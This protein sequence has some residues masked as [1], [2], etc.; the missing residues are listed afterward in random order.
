MSHQPAED[1]SRQACG[2]LILI[3]GLPGS[4]KTTLALSLAGEPA[5][6]RM[7]A[8]AWMTALDINLWEADVRSRVEALQW[9]VAKDLLVAGMTVIIEWGTWAR[10]ERDQLRSEARALGAA[11][12]LRFL[13]AS[14]DEL[15]RRI[16]ARD[17]EDPPVTRHDVAEW[18][19]YLDRPTDA[20]LALFDTPGS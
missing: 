2:R 20:E 1:T 10:T 11:V 12:E 3:C 16:H 15:W 7:S 17:A 13:D 4:G 8:D 18:R 9:S 6:I 5:S 19:T 14:D